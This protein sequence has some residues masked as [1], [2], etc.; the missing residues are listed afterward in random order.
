MKKLNAKILLLFLSV[1]IV[2]V[3][4]SFAQKSISPEKKTLILEL[5]ELTGTTNLGVS[6]KVDKTNIE[7]TFISRI[8][9]EK[10][11]TVVQKQELKQIASEA[12]I[13]INKKLQAFADDKANSIELLVELGIEIFDENFDENELKELVIF[14]RTPVGQK[15]AVFMMT[16]IKKLLDKYTP[17]Y[18]KKFSEYLTKVADDEYSFIN[19]HIKEM[20]EKKLKT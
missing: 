20:K 8:E 9:N 18:T 14:Y 1:F 16:F 5:L 11:L 4:A 10:N 3:N 6:S 17:A 13:R 15:S 7:E 12:N 19:E 2:S